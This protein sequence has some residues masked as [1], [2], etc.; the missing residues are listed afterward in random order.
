[1]SFAP[2]VTTDNSG[3]FYGNALRFATREEAEAN[4]ANLA[5]RWLLVRETRVVEFTDPVN[6]QWVFGNLVPVV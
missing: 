6:Y 5:S 4:A 1:M 2:E 3:K